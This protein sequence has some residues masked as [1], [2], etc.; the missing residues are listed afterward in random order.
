M[1]RQNCCA[2]SSQEEEVISPPD[3]NLLIYCKPARLYN[4]LRIRSLFNVN[5]LLKQGFKDV[6]Q[7][8]ESEV[9]CKL[10]QGKPG[11]PLDKRFITRLLSLYLLL[12]HVIFE[13]GASELVGSINRPRAWPAFRVYGL[14]L[15]EVLSNL[16]DWKVNMVTREANWGAFLIAQSVTE[17]MRLQSYVAQGNPS[18]LH[19]LLA[20]EGTRNSV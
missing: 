14:E 8:I 18:W 7:E 15:T 13:L 10:E 2:K 6:V 4:I 19:G 12:Q 20:E 3:E 5:Q 17:E 11:M 1:C 16:T 9:S